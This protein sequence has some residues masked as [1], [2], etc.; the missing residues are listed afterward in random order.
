M[1]THKHFTM[2]E[3]AAGPHKTYGKNHAQNCGCIAALIA[4]LLSKVAPAKQRG[5][6][7]TLGGSDAANATCSEI[8]QESTADAALKLLSGKNS[9]AMATGTGVAARH[10]ATVVL[11]APPRSIQLQAYRSSARASNFRNI[12]DDCRRD[13]GQELPNHI[14]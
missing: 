9:S 12:Q 14:C 3:T 8:I 6:S 2:T 4:A 7:A 1:T 13:K 5:R 11:L 10:M